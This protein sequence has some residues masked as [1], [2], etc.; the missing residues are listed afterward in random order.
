M[1]MSIHK[2]DI[3]TIT[4]H[5]NTY[6]AHPNMYELIQMHECQPV[7]VMNEIVSD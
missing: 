1:H 4:A 7:K 3:N 2:H 6:E 5:T